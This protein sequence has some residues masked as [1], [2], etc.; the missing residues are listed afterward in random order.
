MAKQRT[1]ITGPKN[2]SSTF[3]FN[4]KPNKVS[5]KPTNSGYTILLKGNNDSGTGSRGNDVIDGSTGYDN[6]IGGEG[7]DILIAGPSKANT[8]D[9]NQLL[10]DIELIKVGEAGG[11][12]ALSG[13]RGSIDRLIG[14]S[15]NLYGT[16][17]ADTIE[18]F[19][20][21]TEL[22][23]DAVEL[24]A[25]AQGGNDIL[26][27]APVT[28]A[29]TT[30]YGDGISFYGPARGGNDQ[31]ISGQS[32]DFMYGDYQFALAAPFINDPYI[33]D[34][35]DQYGFFTA[36]TEGLQPFTYQPIIFDLINQDPANYDP[37]TTA[38]NAT[39]VT[40]YV[41][42]LGSNGQWTGQTTKE[43]YVIPNR[44]ADNN[45]PKGGAD[46]F[47]FKTLNEGDDVIFDF[48]PHEGDRIVF[49]NGLSIA[50]IQAQENGRDTRITYGNSS[51]LL[52][53]FTGLTSSDF[54]FNTDGVAPSDNGNWRP[55]TL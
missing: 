16:G 31:L 25:S 38:A 53:D 30:M 8:R 54:L 50:N 14:D 44:T 26:T 55:V 6:L 1:I 7:N 52:P 15:R 48:N 20:S 36:P 45:S 29:R 17:G 4:N 3:R 9:Q 34:I 41:P 46:R 42:V 13:G 19:G 2:G 18:A 40:F 32:D 33:F 47:V 37:A 5:V 49:T 22:V 28:G 10:G 43:T 39:T 24:Q 12:D 21:I 51:I 23:G 27:G 11:R 35:Y